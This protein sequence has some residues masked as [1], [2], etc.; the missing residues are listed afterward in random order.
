MIVAA[1]VAVGRLKNS[2]VRKAAVSAMP[3]AVKHAGH[4]RLGAGIEVHDRAGEAAGD[5]IAAGEGS[6]DIGGAERHQLLVGVD[7]L[8][9]LG[10]ERLRDRDRLDEA[11]EADQDRGRQEIEPE[12]G[13]ERRQRQRR[14]AT[15]DVAHG[16]HAVTREAEP[17]HRQSRRQH[18]RDRPGFGR[19]IRQPP[20]QPEAEQQ[21]L[22]PRAHPEQ[23]ADRE[24]ADRERRQ[25]GAVRVQGERAPDLDQRVAA[26]P[27]SPGC[28]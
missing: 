10:R 9:P 2:G 17:G 5:R 28:A 3:T 14:Q 16:A 24:G 15:R 21:R 7:P 27:V 8:A 13:V 23:E 6:G 22:Q 25:V 4:R 20:V 12:R 18:G 19:D 26:S 1:S 11:D